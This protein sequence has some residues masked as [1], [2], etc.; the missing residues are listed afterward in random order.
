MRPINVIN[1]NIFWGKIA[2]THNL[3]KIKVMPA[4]VVTPI[5]D[6]FVT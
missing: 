3:T 2:E 4:P 1:P 6:Y 5:S